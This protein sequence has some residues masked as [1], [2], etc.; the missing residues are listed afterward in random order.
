MSPNRS[1]SLGQS[2][3][4]IRS[5]TKAAETQKSWSN[6]SM[7]MKVPITRKFGATSA[8]SAAKPWAKRPPP[9]SLAIKPARTTTSAPATA[10]KKRRATVESPS[11]RRV[12]GGHQ[13]HEGREIH[14]A[15]GQAL[16]GGHVVELVPEVSVVA[17]GEQMPHELEEAR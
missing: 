5:K 8:A 11:K 16:T 6:A 3:F 12:K 4:R 7:E 1:Q 17:V 9:S 14:V 2:C 10:G 15:Q 13:G